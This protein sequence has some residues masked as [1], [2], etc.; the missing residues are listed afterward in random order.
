M[1]KHLSWLLVL[2]LVL[3]SCQRRKF[4]QIEKQHARVAD[5]HMMHGTAEKE[6][7]AHILFLFMR[8]ELTDAGEVLTIDN[9][10]KV[11]GLLKDVGSLSIP[12]SEGIRI[13]I[14]DADSEQCDTFW[15]EHPLHRHV[16]ISDEQ[17]QL[18]SKTLSLQEAEVS[19]R[20]TAKT[21]YNQVIVEAIHEN[22]NVHILTLEPYKL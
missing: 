9:H 15:Q 1:M 2:A 5:S 8:M 17:G 12:K 11:E 22:G 3:G 7:A 4:K 19:L 21:W 16:E 13:L 20:V 14:F 18:A 6:Q 10:L